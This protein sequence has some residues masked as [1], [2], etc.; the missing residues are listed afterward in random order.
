MSQL[1]ALVRGVG[2]YLKQVSGEGKWEE[3]LERCRCEGVP[4]VSRREFERH[5]AEHR[6][7]QGPSRCC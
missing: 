2:W 4:P 3:Y 6:E 5:R 1:A 7:Q